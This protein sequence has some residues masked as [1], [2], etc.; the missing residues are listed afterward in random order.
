M[1]KGTLFLFT[2]LL[3]A[4]FSV[5]SFAGGETGKSFISIK[6]MT[7]GMCVNKVK[8]ALNGVDGV[9]KAE[10]GLKLEVAYVEYDKS[11]VKV[12]D[13]EKAIIKAGYTAND[14][15]PEEKPEEKKEEKKEKIIKQ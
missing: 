10:V 12:E 4:A 15:K 9:T 5:M 7:C 3:I 6:G 2:I 8:K 13:L 1:K 11:K 14:K